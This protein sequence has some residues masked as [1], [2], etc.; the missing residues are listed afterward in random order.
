[1]P[2]AAAPLI[3]RLRLAAGLTLLA[4]V[5][6]HL[7]NHALGLVS[8]GA[9]EAGLTW[10]LVLWRSVPGTLAL[11]GAFLTHL[12]LGLWSLYRRRTLRMP[13]WEAAQLVLGLAIP[14]LLLFHVAG[15]RLTDDLLGTTPS[16]ARVLLFLWTVEPVAGIRQVLLLL[17]AWIHGC[18]GVHFWLRF[19]LWYGWAARVL[20]ALALLVPVLALLGFGRGR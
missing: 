4:Y 9:M 2:V 15:T 14:T 6:S 19:W 3:R 18:M 12:A 1:M 17:I 13:P 5:A 10:A 7:L 16:Y 8:Y 20:Y 11:Y